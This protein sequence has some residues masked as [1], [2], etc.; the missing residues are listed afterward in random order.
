MKDT[1]ILRPLKG[2]QNTHQSKYTA[3]NIYEFPHYIIN[4]GKNDFSFL[5]Y[6]SFQFIITQAEYQE[7]NTFGIS[8][9]D[10]IERNAII[11]FNSNQ[12]NHE[13]RYLIE[14]LNSC[15]KDEVNL[16]IWDGDGAGGT[17]A[18]APEAEM[19]G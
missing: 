14:T 5:K 16:G 1:K 2:P 8:L 15:K 12:N 17:A 3:R 19:G 13:P 7:I 10:K 6:P 9:L 4:I 11:Q 18:M